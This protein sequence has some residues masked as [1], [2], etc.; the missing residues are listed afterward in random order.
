M[1]GGFL[2][3]LLLLV[4]PVVA[5]VGAARAFSGRARGGAV[6]P[7][8]GFFQ[9]AVTYGLL[10]VVAI[11]VSGLLSRVF[12][13]GRVMVSGQGELARDLSFTVVGT[14]LLVAMLLWARR[15][16][17]KDPGE[18]QAPALG[19]FVMAATLTALASALAA[20]NTVLAW[21]FQ[22]RDYDLDV[23]RG[24]AQVLVWGAVWV[25]MWRVHTRLSSPGAARVHHLVGT[26]ITGVV[27]IAGFANVVAQLLKRAFGMGGVSLVDHGTSSVAGSL[28]VL[29][30]GLLGWS[31]YWLG[32]GSRQQRDAVWHGYVLLAGVGAGFVMVVAAASTVLYKALVWWVGDPA[33]T[34]ARTH[35]A[36]TPL[37]LGFTT[38][39]G[40]WWLHHRSFLGSR[41]ERTEIVRIY[42]YLMSGVSLIAAAVGLSI[43]VVAGIEAA[44]RGSL[45]TK[46]GAV[47]TLLTAATLLVVGGPLWWV[48]WHRIQRVASADRDTELASPTRRIYLYVLFGVGGIAAIVSLLVAVY[49]LFNDLIGG[50][51]SSVTLRDMRY[52][53]GVL[54]ST[55]LLAAYHWTVFRQERDVAVEFGGRGKSVLLIGPD[56]HDA[57]REIAKRTGARVQHWKRTDLDGAGWDLDRVV[58]LVDKSSDDEIV[59][60]SDPS[61][62]FAIPIERR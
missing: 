7:V 40:L 22:A 35:F 27:T 54:V 59:I 30:V 57:V 55:A 53:V 12:D 28:P 18:A 51:V 62:P 26:A 13:L 3:S 37:A 50:T 4:L 48:F 46:S 10:F 39:G 21:V 2:A 36:S 61:G 9:Y 33:T 32:T 8:R 15:R 56:D 5:I 20:L 45:I 52:A 24:I 29:I 34:D 58:Q 49:Q 47:N 14:P 38:A 6:Q 43:T 25:L 11:G 23:A 16:L 31:V 17:A 60:V 41:Q 1:I 44:V 19:F 42:E